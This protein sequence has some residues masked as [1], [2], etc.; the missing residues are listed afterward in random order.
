[1]S[2]L[3]Q[4]QHRFWYRH[5][6]I[7]FTKEIKFVIY[8]MS[9]PPSKCPCDLN[10]HTCRESA[11]I[12][13][14]REKE[15][16]QRQELLSSRV[17]LIINIKN[18]HIFLTPLTLRGLRWQDMRYSWRN[19][20]KRAHFCWLQGVYRK[21]KIGQGQFQHVLQTARTKQNETLNNRM[22]EREREGK[23]GKY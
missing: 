23:N 3:V 8:K 10:Q 16:E 17:A 1:M 13:D 12:T 22:R 11:D 18:I 9:L 5:Q 14:E 7:I 21:L 4:V 6:C 19:A 15:R 20:V 2:S